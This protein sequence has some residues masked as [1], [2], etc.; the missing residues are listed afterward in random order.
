MERCGLGLLPPTLPGLVTTQ[1]ELQPP[2]VKLQT[3]EIKINQTGA[4]GEIPQVLFCLPAVIS[5]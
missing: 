4:G 5:V 3:H 2:E 1:P